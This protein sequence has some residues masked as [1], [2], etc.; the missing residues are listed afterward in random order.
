MALVSIIMPAFNAEKYIEECVDSIIAQSYAD[1]ELIIVDDG[2]TDSTPQLT[3]RFSG[4]DPRIRVVHRENGGVS[5]ARNAG[6]D[7]AKGEYVV[8]IDADDIVPTDSLKARMNLADNTDMVVA[9]YELFSEDRVIERMPACV[10]DTWNNHDTVRNIVVPGEIGYQGY[11]VNKLFRKDI[12]DDNNIRFEEGI[13]FNEDRLFCVMYAVHC[14]VV[15]LTGE[16]VY[17][18]R[19]TNTNA[20]STISKMTDRDIDRFMSEFLA[21]DLVLE[22]LKEKY[23]DCFY[24]G[25]I[26]AQHRAI[27]LK[28]TANEQA[29]RIKRSLNSRIRKYGSIALRAPLSVAGIRKKMKILGH[30]FLLR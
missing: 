13:A 25:A 1:W 18:Y 6:L 2:S 21:F 8:F 3:D 23:T 11:T 7:I 29:A 30:M 24:F 16:P 4:T 5:K 20:T 26:D 12:I 9:G 14:N 10:R 22:T 17:R 19:I 28:K 15:R 27:E